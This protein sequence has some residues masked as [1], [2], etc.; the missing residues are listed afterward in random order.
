MGPVAQ[1]DQSP[2]FT[3]GTITGIR[4]A[5]MTRWDQPEAHPS[6]VRMV[7]TAR[8]GQIGPVA[9]GERLFDF[10]LIASVLV[11]TSKVS[12]PPQ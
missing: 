2:S 4:V 6:A 9:R 11:P 7:R 1:W 3:W 8:L 12:Q 10:S 5:K